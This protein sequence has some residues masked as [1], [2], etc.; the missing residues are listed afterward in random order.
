MIRDLDDGS[1]VCNNM[2]ELEVIDQVQWPMQQWILLNTMILHGVKNIQGYRY[3]FT[4]SIKPRDLRDL[5][6]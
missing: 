5:Y 2:D 4:V 6:L 1:V 3:N